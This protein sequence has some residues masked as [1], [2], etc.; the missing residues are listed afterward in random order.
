MLYTLNFCKATEVRAKKWYEYL[1]CF[2]L[3]KFKSFTLL[4]KFPV[5]KLTSI[6]DIIIYTF[7]LLSCLFFMTSFDDSQS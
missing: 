4:L 7:V 6:P 2:S 5:N 3:S 1:T